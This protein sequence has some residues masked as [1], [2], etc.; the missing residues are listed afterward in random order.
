MFVPDNRSVE[1]FC[2]PGV[3]YT[4]GGEQALVDYV[5]GENWF[6]SGLWQGYKGQD[7]EA[8]VDLKELKEINIINARFLHDTGPWIFLPKKVVYSI[9]NDGRNFTKVKELITQTDDEAEGCIIEE[10]IWETQE[11]NARYIK[12]WAETYGILPDWHL[13]AGEESWMFID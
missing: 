10:Y 13:S 9:S 5:K 3:Q 6:R 7:F 1:V 8:V 12:V 4:A 2:D 11:I